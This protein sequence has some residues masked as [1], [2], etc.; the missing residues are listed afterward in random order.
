MDRFGGI[1]T[2]GLW[3]ESPISSLTIASF[4]L[5]GFSIEV[6]TTTTTIAPTVPSSG[7]AR[8]PKRSH[9]LT[10]AISL[11][12]VRRSVT[13]PVH[14]AALATAVRAAAYLRVPVVNTAK[15]NLRHEK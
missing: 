8:R 2:G 10:I 12:E 7:G 13:I 11:G 5:G 4:G 14:P 6:T 1:L 15:A 3:S 9:T